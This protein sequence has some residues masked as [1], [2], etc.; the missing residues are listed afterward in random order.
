MITEQSKIQQTTNAQHHQHQHELGNI[1]MANTT[2]FVER[3][4]GHFY[5]KEFACG[6]GAA[7]VNIGITYPIYKMIFRQMLHGVP[8]T[9]A[10]SQ[11]RHEGLLY[12][13]RGMFPPLA[14]KTVSLSIMF[15]VFDGTRRYLVDDYHM[16]AYKA[17]LIA[18]IAA[19]T[20]ETLLLPFERVQTLLADSKYHK[21]FAN[22]QKAF[23][24]VLTNHGFKELYR[25]I[26][27]VLWR[28]GPSNA[29]FFILREEASLHLPQR[30]SVSTKAAQ[31]FI[32]GA[33]IGASTSTLFYPLNVI[34]VAMQSE[35][36]HPSESMWKT[37]LKIYRDRGSSIAYFYR[38][39]GFNTARSFIS[40]GVMNTAYENLKHLM[41][42]Y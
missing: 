17:K 4:F 7:F 13:Y 12:L 42:T 22:T 21:Y 8:I 40:W 15:G 25:G 34:K 30:S 20:V 41:S 39:C 1:P 9:S 32:A 37:C 19:G 2:V 11:L 24:Y 38:G 16:N 18:G 29:M 5:W 3:F 36:G 27:P 6:C 14:Q 31:E 23:G 10:F 33:I 28:N 26:V 35:M